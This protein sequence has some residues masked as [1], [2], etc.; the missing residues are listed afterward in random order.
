MKEILD[1]VSKAPS[2]M[3]SDITQLTSKECMLDV[4]KKKKEEKARSES[5]TRI[6]L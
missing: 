3:L 2:Q 1:V 5:N 6:K 4:Q